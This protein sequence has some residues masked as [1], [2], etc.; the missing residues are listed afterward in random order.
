MR[1]FSCQKDTHA[2]G[3]G[4]RRTR[5]CVQVLT[6][7][8]TAFAG[9]TTPFLAFHLLGVATPLPYPQLLLAYAQMALVP[10]LAAV[11]AHHPI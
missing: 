9:I 11:G 1:V 5:G 2:R 8:S 3:I 6:T 7:L 4:R 10:L